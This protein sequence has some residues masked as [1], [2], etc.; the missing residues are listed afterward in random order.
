MQRFL[1]VGALALAVLVGGCAGQEKSESDRNGALTAGAVSMTVRP[2]ETSQTEIVE[3]FGPPDML[4]HKDDLDVWI[5]DKTTYKYEQKR[6]YFNVIIYGK[7]GVAQQS[8][9][10]STMLILYFDADGVVRDYRL[11]VVK[12]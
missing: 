7:G 9:S 11:S 2:G 1:C 3:A 5:Y 10:E 6:G 4:T 8:S 12:Y